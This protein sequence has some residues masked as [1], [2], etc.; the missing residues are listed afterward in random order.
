MIKIGDRFVKLGALPSDSSRQLDV[1]RHDG[2][3][4]H[5]LVPSKRPTLSS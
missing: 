5:K 3:M 2:V 4:A 1:L